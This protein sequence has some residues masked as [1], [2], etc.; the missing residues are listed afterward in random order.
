MDLRIRALWWSLGLIAVIASACGSADLSVDST[1]TA[2]TD[3][4]VSPAT[5]ERRRQ[6]EAVENWLYLIDVNL[7]AATVDEIVESDHDMVVLDF[8]PSE[9][10]NTDY[11]MADVVERLHEADGERLVLAYVDIGQAED[12]RVYWEPDWRIGD[13]DWIVADDPDGWEGNYPVAYWR[14]EWHD[15]W[16]DDGGLVSQIVDAGF[17]GVYLDWVEA[18]SDDSVATAAVRDDVDPVDQMID[19]VAALADTGRDGNPEF[20]VI[21]QNAA[22]LA[23]E[24][25]DYRAIIDA[26]AQEQVWFD[27]AADNDPPGDCPLPRTDDLIDTPAYEASLSDGCLRL[28]DELPDSTLHVSSEEYL[29]A[30]TAVRA[31]G[32][33]VLT[34]DYATDPDNVA[35]VLD[36][37]RQHGFV[38]FV[39]SRLLDEYVPPR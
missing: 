4:Q 35:F 20:I 9:Q 16:L 11:P 26:V 8:I 7:D 3:E 14:Q 10:Q 6:L 24:N 17:D 23:A 34:V 12:Y 21:A 30:L 2:S 25:A 32:L 31:A 22:E 27:G 36:E 38:P 33:P 18:Y 37:S 28:Y 15:V 13:P 1:N 5:D 19:W 29:D 39:G